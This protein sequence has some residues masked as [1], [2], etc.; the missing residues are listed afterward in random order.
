M[1]TIF[2]TFTTTV[3]ALAFAANLF[4]NSIL[5]AFGLVATSV[6]NLTKLQSS[7]HVVEKMKTR[8]KAKKREVTKNFAK[9]S[10]KK[11]ASTA[12][13]AATIGTVAVVVTMASIEVTDYC[14]DKK[15]LQEDANI[16]YGTEDEFDFDRCL[17]EGKEESKIMIDEI[18]LSTMESVNAAMDSTVEYSNEQWLAIKEASAKAYESSEVATNELWNSLKQWITQEN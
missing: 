15:S 6:D 3:A 16:L 12:L 18:K 1:K 2:F 5:G 17:E 9:K 13:A 4:L 10:S 11:V 7:Q 14:E 8:H